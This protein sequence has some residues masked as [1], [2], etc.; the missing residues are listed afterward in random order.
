MKRN[1]L[2]GAG[3]A[4]LACLLGGCRL[5]VPQGAAG[6]DTLIGGYATWESIPYFS[7]HF[8]S[9]DG[10]PARLYADWDS[11]DRPEGAQ[12]RNIFPNV[13]GLCAVPEHD[14]GGRRYCLSWQWGRP[15]FQR[16]CLQQRTQRQ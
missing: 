7:E 11:A 13:T 8:L 9:G 14:G 3:A 1:M 5:A 12:W 2:F 16:P 6:Q 10:S 4:A 15:V